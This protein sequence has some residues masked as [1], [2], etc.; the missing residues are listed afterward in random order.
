MTRHVIATDGVRLAVQEWGDPARRTVVLI[1]GYPDNRNVWARVADLLVDDFH[2]VAYDV[3]GTGESGA[4]RR[5]RGYRLAQLR[6]DLASVIEA[7]SP[8]APVH[9][10]AHD[11][12]SIQTWSAVTSPAFADRVLSFTSISGPSLDLAGRWMRNGRRHPVAFLRQLAASWYILAFQLPLLPELLVRRGALEAIVSHS[13]NLGVARANRTR[14]GRRPR[15][16]QINGIELYRANFGSLIFPAPSPAVCPVQVL[17]P[18]DDVHV[19]VPLSLGAPREFVEDLRAEEVPGNHWVVEHDPT[20]I[21]NRFADFI[22][23]LPRT[24]T[25]I[26]HGHE[27]HPTLH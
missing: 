8:D 9:L 21:A 15:R 13:E 2:V 16:D 25:E 27:E 4:P 22:A 26:A 6:D 12:G 17:A 19:T 24:R 18:T 10:I 1:H 5:R 7:T 3:R 14:S 11:W 23:C 20:L